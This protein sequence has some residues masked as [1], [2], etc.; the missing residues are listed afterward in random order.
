MASRAVL[1]T[2][3]VPAEELA[4][5]PREMPA[6][7]PGEV[8][9]AIAAA[10]L[11]FVDIMIAEGN[12]QVR[13]PLPFTPGSDFAGWIDAVGSGVSPARIGERVCGAG[14][15]G[16]MATEL[17]T[18]SDSAVVMPDTMTWNQGA[19]LTASYTTA[20][21]ALVHR[22]R[23]QPGELLCVLGAAGAVGIAAIQIGKALGATVIASAS[24]EEKRA[25]AVAAGADLAIDSSVEDWRA[26]LRA[27]TGGRAPD[28]VVDT[29]GNRFTELA[30]RS[31]AWNGRLLV[32]GFAAGKIPSIPTNLVL[33]KGVDLVGIN[34][35]QFSQNEPEKRRSMFPEIFRM[36]AEGFIRTP[37]DHAYPLERFGEAVARVRQAPAGRVIVTMN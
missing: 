35:N 17:V 5:L 18:P 9:V 31:L 23:L 6:P 29:L 3:F 4:C 16:A 36:H 27:A 28:V 1:V 32:I 8:R 21:H 12:Y 37:I 22:G 15:G 19:V 13:P 7:G 25:A 33:L 26:Q 30:L 24:T 34:I 20:Y 11:S 10:G 2:E 14:F